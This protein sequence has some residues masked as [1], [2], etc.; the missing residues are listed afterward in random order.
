MSVLIGSTGFVGSHISQEVDFDLSVHRPNL[1]DVRNLET[2]LLVC[3]GLPAEKWRAN[4][5]PDAD[6]INTTALASALA[7]VKAHRAV[8]ISTVDVYQPPVGVDEGDFPAIG[9]EQAYGRNRTWFECFFRTRFPDGLIVRLPGLFAA[10]V[11][12]NLIHDLMHGKEEQWASVNPRSTFQFFDVTKTWEFCSRAHDLGI[13]LLNVSTPPVSAAEVAACFGVD[14]TADGPAA[15]YDMR[16]LH[17][18]SFGGVDGYLMSRDAV[19]AGIAD[20]SGQEV[21]DES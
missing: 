12:K 7:T 19:L 1:Q 2:D 4:A 15:S 21:S 13:D 16:T 18:S 14:L 3:A 20:L 17:A 6:W 9:G 5:D 11:R 10:D 8:L